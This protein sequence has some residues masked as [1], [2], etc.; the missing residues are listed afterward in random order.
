MSNAVSRIE[1]PDP[2]RLIDRITPV[3]KVR[4]EMNALFYGRSGTGK[5]TLACSFPKPLL[6]LD[7]NESGTSS[8]ANLDD[9]FVLSIQEWDDFESI[10]WYIKKN[11]KKYK[12]IVIDTVTR[13][14]DL[15]LIKVMYEAGKDPEEDPITQPDWGAAFKLMKSWII[16]FRDLEPNIVFTAQDRITESKYDEDQ[17]TPEVGPMLTPAVAKA[18]NAAVNIIGQTFIHGQTVTTDKGLATKVTYR[19]RL[20][21]DEFYLTKVRQPKEAKLPKSLV[22]PTYEKLDEIV[23]GTYTGKKGPSKSSEVK[24]IGTTK[25]TKK[26]VKSKISSSKEG[27]NK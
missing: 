16:K 13:L 21:P 5:T 12:T 10:Y 18:L 2:S 24:S 26:K 4:M 25:E 9:V 1:P 17:I 19:L 20:G 6:I 3:G 11:S 15:A 22:D 27:T 23:R 8:V 7:I 14:Q